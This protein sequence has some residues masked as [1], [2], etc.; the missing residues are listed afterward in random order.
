MNDIALDL[1]KA[2]KEAQKITVE[3]HRG[4]FEL[5]TTMLN[6]YINGFTL[7]GSLDNKNSDT[8]WVWLFLITRSF[9]SLRCSVEL[10]KK[11]YYAQAMALIRMVTETYFICGNC[12][13]DQTIADA[14]LHNK[15]NR[16]DGRT[17][18]NYRDLA[19]NMGASVMHEKDYTFECKFAH[20]SSL[21][22][23]IMTTKIDA[24]NRELKPIPVYDEILFMAC[25]ELALKNGI[26][27]TMFLENLLDDLSQEKV[28]IWRLQ[29]RTGIQE[30]SEWLD[31]LKHK[32][33]SKEPPTNIE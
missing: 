28:N 20:T 7:I 25:C 5:L 9:Y 23:G 26:L 1:I 24:S 30:I 10:M 13:N 12:K 4:V 31:G 33:G 15:P 6:L 14:I 11:A 2:E 17:I 16:P 32:Y 18:F 3:Q 29:A 8:D 22:V 21:S 27:M 19:C